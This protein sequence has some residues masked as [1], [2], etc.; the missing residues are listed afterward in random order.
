MPSTGLTSPSSS[1]LASGEPAGTK[2]TWTDL[3]NLYADDAAYGGVAFTGAIV[4]SYWAYV[5]G[6][7]FAVPAD[8]NVTGVEVR[9]RNAYRLAGIAATLSVGL[10]NATSYPR[11]GNVVSFTPIETANPGSY[12]LGGSNEQWGIALTPAYVNAATFA[13][14]LQVVG[15]ELAE[16]WMDQIQ[17]NVYYQPY[18][19][20]LTVTVEASI[21]DSTF[22]LTVTSEASISHSPSLDVSCQASI[23]TSLYISDPSYGEVID[24]AI[25]TVSW[26]LGVGGVQTDY[27]VLIYDDAALTNIVYDSGTIPGNSQSHVVDGPLPNPADIYITVT[28]TIDAP[29][30]LTSAAVHVTTSFSTSTD[31]TGL[32]ATPIGDLNTDPADLPYMLIRWAAP[33]VGALA[34]ADYQVFR[35]VAGQTTYM[36][37]A[38]ISSETTLFYRDYTVAPRTLYEYAVKWTGYQ[39]D[40]LLVSAYQATPALARNVFDFGWL[41]VVGNEAVRARVDS[42]SANGDLAQD[43]RLIQPW[44]RSTPTMHFGEVLSESYSLKLPGRAYQ[45]IGRAG[46]DIWSLVRAFAENQQSGATLCLRL[47]RQGVRIFC[48]MRKPTRRMNQGDEAISIEAVEIYYDESV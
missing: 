21:A 12:V 41:H 6:F 8:A 2:A 15:D 37:I 1:G 47:G 29:A 28:V 31:V 23:G 46:E 32:T 4:Q 11:D 33:D 43:G 39:G 25:F 9:L 10:K 30:Q 17:V 45:A 36:R 5:S 38:I 24:S 35:R 26:D 18:S 34:F 44:G 14:H 16:V 3:A 13:V 7:G 40:Q 27:R 42:W 20:A 19:P 22:G 48:V